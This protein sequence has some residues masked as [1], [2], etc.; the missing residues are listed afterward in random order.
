V[1]TL[2]SVPAGLSE[3]PVA[4]FLLYTAAG[5]AVWISLLAG[6]GY[7][8]EENY[9]A[10]EH[11]LNPVTTIVVVAIVGLYLYRVLRGLIRRRQP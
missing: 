1:R 2:I 9:E 11:W 5:S 3:M 10:V 8:L 6:A 7:I 4:Q